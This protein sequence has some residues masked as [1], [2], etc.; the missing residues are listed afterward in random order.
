[1]IG[2]RLALRQKPGLPD[3][4]LNMTLPPRFFA[5]VL[6]AGRRIIR[7]LEWFLRPRH[8]YLVDPPLFQHALGFLVLT[9]GLL[10]LLPVPVPFANFLPAWTIVLT[11]AALMERDAY[12]AILAVFMFMLTLAFFAALAWGGT[13][14]VAWLWE[15]W[16]DAPASAAPA[17]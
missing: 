7:G 9:A 1:M 12:A 6:G 14:A 17:P 10:L 3:R 13:E 16:N 8:T 2:F 11:A 15:A 4:L 5:N